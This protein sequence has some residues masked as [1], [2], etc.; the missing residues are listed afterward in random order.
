MKIINQ[1][2]LRPHCSAKKKTMSIVLISFP[3]KKEKYLNLKYIDIGIYWSHRL[4]E[5]TW[6]SECQWKI[7]RIVKIWDHLWKRLIFSENFL[8]MFVGGSKQALNCF[9][10]EK[11]TTIP[12][13]SRKIKRHMFISLDE[14]RT[15]SR[16]WN[17]ANFLY[18]K[19]YD[20]QEFLPFLLCVHRPS[21]LL[22]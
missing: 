17:R 14:E 16:H 20:F 3:P 8:H 15:G 5:N 4:I 1:Q 11:I 13:E 22:L 18:S 7:W 19:T 21:F 12:L 6:P 10:T 9:I 2:E